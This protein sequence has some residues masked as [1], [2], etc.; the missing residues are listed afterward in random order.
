MGEWW[1]DS[2]DRSRFQ[3]DRRPSGRNAPNRGPVEDGSHVGCV[4]WAR[5]TAPCSFPVDFQFRVMLFDTDR[6]LA[7]TGAFT[8]RRCLRSGLT[9]SLGNLHVGLCLHRVGRPRPSSWVPFLTIP[10]EELDA[11]VELLLA[12]R[13]R[14]S[15]RWLTVTLDDGYEDAAAWVEA[16]ADRY[17]E[18]EFLLAVCPEKAEKQAGFRWD[19]VEAAIVQGTPRRE[20]QQLFAAP[21]DVE[22]EN[23]REDLR[24]LAERPEFRLATV[25]RLRTL[26]R[27]ENVALANHSNTHMRFTR[28]DPVQARLDLDRSHCDFARLF[29]SQRHFAFPFGTP[30]LEFD[31]SHVALLR[32][33]GDFLVWSTEAR[34]FHPG[35]R[36]LGAVLPRFPVPGAWNH[37]SIAAWIAG[38]TALFRGRGTPHH[39]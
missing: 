13:P 26:T 39:F 4:G 20:A 30:R 5:G 11:L 37:R 22:R 36:R 16:R 3:G 8:P 31:E 38:R 23:D 24:R 1:Q 15:G 12:S 14:A 17:P 18:V 19:L 34:P 10:E 33:H 29:G 2:G 21:C 27:R 6:L 28:L 7:R 35:E 32:E 9:L 25:E